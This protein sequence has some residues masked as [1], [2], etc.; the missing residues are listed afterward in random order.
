MTMATLGYIFGYMLFVIIVVMV[1]HG[2][3][4]A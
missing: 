3:T 4:K 1:I 2:G